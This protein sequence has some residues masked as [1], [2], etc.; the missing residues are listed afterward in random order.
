MIFGGKGND[1]I[2]GGYGND[3]IYGGHGAD[4]IIGSLVNQ[5]AGAPPAEDE[6]DSDDE[7]YGNGNDL[8]FGGRGNDNIRGGAGHDRL[9]GGNGSD[10]ISGGAGEDILIGGAGGDHLLGGSENDI[11]RFDSVRHITTKKGADD[12]IV[13]FAQGEDKIDLSSIDAATDSPGHQRFI[14]AGEG[15]LDEAFSSKLHYR[16]LDHVNKTVVFGDVNGDR[17]PDFYLEIQGE[18]MLQEADFIL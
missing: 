7:E 10:N 5:S 9:F 13:D 18:H 17:H 1:L 4:T 16:Y 8:I 3:E 11:F 15:Q 2:Y 6:F 12:R 14:F